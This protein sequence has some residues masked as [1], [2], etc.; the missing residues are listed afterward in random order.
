MRRVLL[1]GMP[2]IAAA[3][4]AAADDFGA[5][6]SIHEPSPPFHLTVDLEGA[7]ARTDVGSFDDNQVSAAG[8]LQ[9]GFRRDAQMSF[10][11]RFATLHHASSFLPEF[12]PADQRVPFTVVPIEVA[13]F[14]RAETSVVWGEAYLG[15]SFDRL[16]VPN[17]SE[18][19]EGVTAGLE[20][21]IDCVRLGDAR[22]GIFGNVQTELNGLSYEALMGGLAIRYG[23][24]PPTQP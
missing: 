16:A 7:I 17:D 15:A 23:V 4:L 2:L 5:A 6:P 20:G 21:G 12:T 24:V 3:R 1:V 9:V 19:H 10:G 8:A 22:I 13:A 11:L 14:A 18:W